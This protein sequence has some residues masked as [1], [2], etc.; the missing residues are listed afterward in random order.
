[1][2]IE[3]GFNEESWQKLEES[4]SAWWNHELDRPMVVINNFTPNEKFKKLQEKYPGA[5][6]AAHFPLDEPAE[7]II[8]FFQA[9]LEST[10]LY[11]DSW[12]RW[13]PNFGPGIISGFLGAKVI[14]KSDTVWF[15]PPDG[16]EF[17]KLKIEFDEQNK[18]Y[19]RIMELTEAAI[20][21]WQDKVNISFTDLGGNYDV[22]L[23]FRSTEKLLMDLYDKPD[24]L[25]DYMRK[26]TKL[27]LECYKKFYE[28]ISINNRGTSAWAPLWSPGKHYILQCDF[29]YMISPQMFEE[30]V[31]DDL[32]AC[33]D[34]LDHGFY[35]LDGKGQIP[36]LDLLL[37]IEN[38]CGIQWIPGGESGWGQAENRL[39]L[40]KR[41]IDGGKLCQVYATPESAMKIK[42][43]L[44][45]KGFAFEI[46]GESMDEKS[47]KELIEELCK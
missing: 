21:K 12:P 43:E 7:N 4:W 2:S 22:L 6:C 10:Q 47:A 26:V 35:H 31:L 15:E 40:L 41:I 3:V 33:C 28:K 5:G 9:M 23:H 25:K 24:M 14:V 36:H 18:W 17:E 1:V 20:E 19:R 13:W 45:G 32:K 42:N 27:W 8:D 11:G 37:G 34:Y 46:V 29:S 44:G 39:D 38:L 16:F 30:F